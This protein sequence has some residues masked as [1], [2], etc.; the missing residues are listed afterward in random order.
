MQV[1][2]QGKAQ[3][4]KGLIIVELH[5]NVKSRKHKRPHKV[6]DMKHPVSNLLSN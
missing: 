5:G 3:L 6:R 4:N 1:K 2:Y